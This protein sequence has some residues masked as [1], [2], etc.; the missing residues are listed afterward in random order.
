MKSHL[1]KSRIA[2]N[3]RNYV[4]KPSRRGSKQQ[5]YWS[6]AKPT[7]RHLQANAQ[8]P[9]IGRKFSKNNKGIYYLN[10]RGR[11]IY[12]SRNK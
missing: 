5:I 12:I 11:K 8:K 3:T 4:Y 2:V 10:D 1:I 7:V 6:G 9:F